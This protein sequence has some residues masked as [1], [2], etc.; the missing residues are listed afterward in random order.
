M[1][2]KLNDLPKKYKFKDIFYLK[3]AIYAQHKWNPNNLQSLYENMNK[4][5]REKNLQHITSGYNVFVK[6][7]KSKEDINDM[8]I[9]VY[10]GINPNIL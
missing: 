4:Y 7:V 8:I 6:E 3:N 10:I 2:G 1:I 9:D 5:S